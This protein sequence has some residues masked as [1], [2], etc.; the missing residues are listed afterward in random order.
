MAGLKLGLAARLFATQLLV[1]AAA[2][3]TLSLVAAAVGPALF[4]VHLHRAADGEVASQVRDHAEQAFRVASAL[5]V[6]IAVAVAVVV[7]LAVSAVASRRL[8]RPVAALAAAATDVADSNYAVRVAPTGL[9][10]E[11]DALTSAFNALAERLQATET[12]RRRL[13]SDLAHEMRTPV[14]TLEACAEGLADGVV[15]PDEETLSVILMQ[16]VRLRRLVED[17]AAVSRAEEHQL[18][19]HLA[20]ARPRLS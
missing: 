13:L 20:P 15:A 10:T 17:I 5:S 14:A 6:T 16:T 18:E 1:L 7:A 4:H 2:A 12:T 11:F 8:S 3:V 9:G 19:L